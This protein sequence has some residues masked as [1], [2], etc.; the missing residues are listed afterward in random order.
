MSTLL[1]RN[2]RVLV[3]MDGREI[4]RGGMFIRDGFIEDVGTCDDIPGVADAIVDLEGHVVMPGLVNAHHHLYQT[5]TRAFPG[6]QDVALFDWL[7]A[8]YPVWAR[9]TPDHVR[10]ATRLGLAELA[11]S[12]ATTVFDHQYLWPNGTRIDDQFEAAEGLGVRFHASRGS[13]SL[14][15]SAG[16]LPPDDVVEDESTILDDTQRAIEMFH[17]PARGALS[18]V[19]VAPCSP[20]SVSSDLMRESAELARSIGVRLHTHLAETIDEQEY[21]LGQFGRRPVEYMETVGWLGEDVWYAHAIH[22]EAAEIDVI[23]D[24]GTGV[25]HCPTSNMRLASGLAPVN[26]YLER[27]VPVGLG[28]DGSASNDSSN[29]LAEARQALLLNRLG[30]SPGVGSGAQLSA[31]QA[32]HMATA[33][34][35]RVL[36]RDDIGILAP[37]YA[38]DFIAIDTRR[39]ELA[40][41]GHDPVAAA[42]L[43]IVDRVDRS[44]VAGEPVVVDGAMATVDVTDLIARHNRLSTQLTG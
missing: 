40:G 11:L 25:A 14:G 30:V 5:L 18:R 9:L 7:R 22:V 42:V 19:V 2:A 8:L 29:M 33:G 38:A 31:R 27:E 15:E 32:L 21:C 4:E 41:A 10:T 20:F 44:W 1:V 36:G 23:A 34:G 39:L 24:T 37:G 6:A 26:R 35:A 13:M 28:V 43:C 3:T 16:G 17:D 12:G